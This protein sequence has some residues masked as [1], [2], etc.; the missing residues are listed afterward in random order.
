MDY[1]Q[2]LAIY[3]NGWFR[4]AL[5]SFLALMLYKLGFERPLPIL[6]KI[7]VYAVLV[8]G[9]YPLVI[10]YAFGLPIVPA[11][12]AAIL[13]MVAVRFREKRY[14]KDAPSEG[15]TSNEAK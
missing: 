5:I 11:L 1:D 14:K 2:L 7:V 10:L 3:N 4:Y 13:F 6:K 15:E 12:I 9:C 8:I